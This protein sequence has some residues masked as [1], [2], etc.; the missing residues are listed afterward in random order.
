MLVAS[1]VTVSIADESQQSVIQS[2]IQPFLCRVIPGLLTTF[3]R[4]THATKTPVVFNLLFKLILKLLNSQSVAFFE[5][6]LQ[7]TFLLFQQCIKENSLVLQV[8]GLIISVLE[9]NPTFL[10]WL[11]ANYDKVNALLI[12][13]IYV[14]L[15]I[16]R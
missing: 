1:L 14:A 5:S 12:N 6:I 11:H 16:N 3:Q 15:L 4:F 8:F 13:A 10:S 2:V 7:M 9:K